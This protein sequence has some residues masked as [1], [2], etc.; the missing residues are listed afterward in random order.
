MQ[1]PWLSDDPDR[2]LQCQRAALI[3]KPLM[4]RQLT[5]AQHGPEGAKGG[6]AQTIAVNLQWVTDLL[7]VEV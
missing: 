2:F 1:G 7:L 5:L 6:E 4:E 3:V